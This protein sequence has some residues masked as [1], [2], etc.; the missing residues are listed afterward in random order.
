MSEFLETA[1]DEE[2]AQDMAQN[3]AEIATVNEQWAALSGA[4]NEEE[5]APAP[6]VGHPMVSG[7]C[8]TPQT[9][10]PQE[11][12]D[13]CGRWGAGTRANPAKVWHPCSCGCHLG[14]TYECN[15]GRLIAEAPRWLGN[16]EM[17]YVHIDADGN[18]IGEDC[19]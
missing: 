6:V 9:A 13:R 1:P 2:W 5:Q 3:E 18:A 17:T 7:H 4:E 12:H 15:C 14:E 8:A 19:S 10:H 16:G 11:S